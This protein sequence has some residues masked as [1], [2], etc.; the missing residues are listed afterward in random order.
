MEHALETE[1]LQAPR[2]GLSPE[3][4]PA[5]LPRT[6][7]HLA[8]TRAGMA[9]AG[10]DSGLAAVDPSRPSVHAPSEPALSYRDWFETSRRLALRLLGEPLGRGDRVLVLSETRR[11]WFQAD[12]AILSS[13]GLTVPVY[14]TLPASQIESIL[15]DS[16]ATAAVV[17]RPAL[18]EELM[19]AP[20]ARQQL[21]FVLL[22]EGEAEPERGDPPVIPLAAALR[23]GERAAPER[24]VLL[25][26]ILESLSGDDPATVIYTSGTSGR[27][28]GV[29]LTHRNLLSSA[30][31]S[32]RRFGIRPDDVYLSFLP[33]SHVLE[34]VVHLS[35][36]WAGAHLC[37][38]EGLDRLEH[39][40]QRVRPTIVVGVPRLYEKVLRSV[41]NRASGLG[42]PGR[43][44]VRLAVHAA[45]LAGRRGPGSLPRGP[46]GRVW[47]AMVYRRVRK[48]LGGRPR[49]LI[50]G[51]SPLGRREALFFNG[52][53][54]SLVEG[55]GLTE[56]A[57]V[58][59]VSAPGAWRLGSVG[60]L[61]PEVEA[62]ITEEGEICLRGPSIMARYHN[63][64]ERTAQ[65]LRQGWLHTGDVGHITPDGYLF[66]TDRLKDLIATA[67]GKK[68]APQHIEG[69]LRRSPLIR[70]VVVL[71]EKRPFLAALVFP[72]LEHLRAR[73][74]L[75]LPEGPDL[76]K[77][78]HAPA[79]R[80]IYRT[81]IDRQSVDLAPHEVVREFRLLSRPPTV[82]A[83]ELTPTGKVRRKTIA[84]RYGEEIAELYRR[85]RR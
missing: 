13:G 57:S 49:I 77:A 32:A 54:L 11:E 34:R 29:V 56:T 69:L 6:L 65:A 5:V 46:L 73:F 85:P 67:Q 16:G 7:V 40:L 33:M 61:L 62:R 45:C 71:G 21:R 47:E 9:P 72:E 38:G 79:V 15:I 8:L 53:G 22:L 59:S 31:S 23:E 26:S 44:I 3:P 70:E 39:D 18:L 35:M 19:R 58:V 48:A 55:Y 17:S 14:P 76:D 20:S 41:E 78:L 82:E 66:L 1:A 80:A 12:L 24:Q 25:D 84:E 74:G 36:L 37:Y 64:E 83:G 68:V 51:G 81:E 2:P 27:M 42:A 60:R 28:K 4:A 52:A 30:V 43:A 10:G 63:D 75:R 50:S